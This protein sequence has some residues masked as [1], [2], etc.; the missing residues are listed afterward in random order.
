[1]NLTIEI[2]RMWNVKP[3][4]RPVIT[5]ATETILSHFMSGITEKHEI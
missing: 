3:K 2:Q 5:G 4:V 1:M